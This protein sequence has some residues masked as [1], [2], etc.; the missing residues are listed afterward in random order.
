MDES[1]GLVVPVEVQ[2]TEDVTSTELDSELIGDVVEDESTP[3]DEMCDG[4]DEMTVEDGVATAVE[5]QTGEDVVASTADDSDAT[6]EVEVEDDSAVPVDDNS[7]LEEA[8]KS[9]VE[10]ESIASAVDDTAGSLELL[11][12]LRIE[13]TTEVN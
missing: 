6:C 8:T 13:L 9:P 11:L 7:A 10:E 4:T 5:V 2:T 12:L 3:L 1:T